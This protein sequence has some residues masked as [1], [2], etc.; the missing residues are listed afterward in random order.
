[1]VIDW[2]C[3]P[4][5]WEPP[6]DLIVHGY[7]DLSIVAG[8]LAG[9]ETER[10]LHDIHAWNKSLISIPILTVLEEQLK[11]FCVV[12][13]CIQWDIHWDWFLEGVLEVHYGGVVLVESDADVGD[14]EFGGW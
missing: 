12:P 10:Y 7:N 11:D 3:H 9:N 5:N 6:L 4:L 2:F 1:M 13:L 14:G 8:D